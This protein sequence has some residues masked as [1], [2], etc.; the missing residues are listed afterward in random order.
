MNRDL[1]RTPV[2]RRSQMI[3]MNR[4][5]EMWVR[6]CILER[7]VVGKIGRPAARFWKPT[8][9]LLRQTHATP[10][11]SG[12]HGI[13]QGFAQEKNHMLGT[14]GLGVPAPRAQRQDH[15]DLERYLRWE[16]GGRAP[17]GNLLTEAARVSRKARTTGRSR[18]A[19]GIPAFIAAGRSIAAGRRV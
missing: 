11:S 14:Y 17:G 2:S 4:D 8:M 6:F 10:R 15:A 3:R 9:Y 16:Y 7:T 18:L 19:G 12:F 13:R 1:D 5:R